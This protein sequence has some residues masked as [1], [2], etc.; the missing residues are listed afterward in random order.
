[1]VLTRSRA[2]SCTRVTQQP[3]EMYSAPGEQVL[4]GAMPS[5]TNGGALFVDVRSSTPPLAGRPA[6]AGASAPSP[7]PL[8]GR[9]LPGY[10]GMPQYGHAPPVASPQPPMPTPV[11]MTDQQLVFLLQALRSQPAQGAPLPPPVSTNLSNCSARFNGSG[12]VR[13]FTDSVQ[14]YTVLALPTRLRYEACQC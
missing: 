5:T 14:I 11:V 4:D 8:Y 10:S 13:A 7:P 9:E 6:S 12:D 1:M 3:A 2:N